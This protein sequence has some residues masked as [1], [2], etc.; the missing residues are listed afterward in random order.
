MKKLFV[1]CL[2]VVGIILFSGC[3]D[4]EKM[5]SK[6]S[7]SSQ[8]SMNE[9]SKETSASPSI[10]IPSPLDNNSS[11]SVPEI[12][13]PELIPGE[14]DINITSYYFVYLRDN[15]YT[16]DLV[17]KNYVIYHLSIKTNDT[18]ALNFSINKL[19]LQTGN[20][21]FTPADPGTITKY[22]SGWVLS[23]IENENRLNDTHILP[24]QTLEGIVIFQVDNYNTL[25]DRSFSLRYNTTPIPSTSYEKSLE[26]LAVAEQFDYSIAFDMPPYDNWELGDY[27]YD[28]PEP[29]NYHVWANWVNRTVFESYKKY[30]EMSLPKQKPGNIPYAKIA[31][32]VKVIP[33]QD[34]TVRSGEVWHTTNEGK[35]KET[36]LHVVD[37]TGEELFNKSIIPSYRDN[38]GLAIL[39]NQKYRPFS[40][41]MPQMFIPQATIVHFS[42]NSMY[43][44]GMSARLTFNDQDIILDE[45]HNITLARY[46]N[47]K[48]V[49]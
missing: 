41:N 10:S 6:T 39:D 7:T 24:H 14:F 1:I 26:A 44:W 25:F 12:S 45:Q 33:E 3:I 2:L 21:S 18:N 36:Y 42:F 22:F 11:A 40:E 27:S 8:S 46:D 19:Q 47:H 48:V 16:F 49:S 32:A 20:Q 29:G 4:G 31:Y 43:G 37:D 15:E 5:N 28:P 35:Y 13:Q 23:E 38:T 9:T 30:D 17:E 34:L